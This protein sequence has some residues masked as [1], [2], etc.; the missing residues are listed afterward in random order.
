MLCDRSSGRLIECWLFLL[1]FAND[2]IVST[3]KIYKSCGNGHESGAIMNYAWKCFAGDEDVIH[4]ISSLNR[5]RRNV[6]TLSAL[7]L[8]WI[9]WFARSDLKII[10]TLFES[11]RALMVI[12]WLNGQRQ[13]SR[14]VAA[15]FAYTAPTVHAHSRTH[16]THTRTPTVGGKSVS[17]NV[18]NV[19]VPVASSYFSSFLASRPPQLDSFAF[20]GT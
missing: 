7:F 12:W 9:G 11:Q 19:T 16:T 10:A 18:D 2:A 3:S 17:W 20:R 6:C 5:D 1:T 8:V 14:L 15:L 4:F 13:Y